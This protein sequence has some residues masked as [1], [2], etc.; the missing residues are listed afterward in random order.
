MSALEEQTLLEL[1]ECDSLDKIMVISLR[2]RG[3][4]KFIKTLSNC[5]N[6][7]IA[8]LEFNEP[9]LDELKF[10]SYF[11]NLVKLDLSNCKINV[12]P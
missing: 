2:K 8:F 3:Y 6:L 11:N 4:T 5:A 7:R 12:L 9:P 10:L 1:T